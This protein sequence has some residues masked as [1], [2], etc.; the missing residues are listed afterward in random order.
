[1][2][3]YLHIAI[4][5][6]SV[7]LMAYAQSDVYYIPSKKV[8][9]VTVKNN[10]SNTQSTEYY[11]NDYPL[12]ESDV[13]SS[14]Y[15]QD[16]RDVDEYNRRGKGSPY[17]EEGSE[18]VD[19][20]NES[21]SDE[22]DNYN[23]SK[24]I[25]RFYSP[26]GVIVSSPFYW[27]VCYS[28]VWDAYYDG[29]AYLLPSYSFW[30]YAYDPWHYNRWWY[31]SCWDFTWGWYDPW[32][33]S[34]YWG[35]HRPLYWGWDRPCYGGWSHG[36]YHHH[37]NPGWNPG[38]RNLGGGRDFA[39]NSGYQMGR[40]SAGGR[41]MYGGTNNR[42][43]VRD[44]SAGIASR[45]SLSKSFRSGSF[46]NKTRNNSSRNVGDSY[47]NG[48]SRPMMGGGGF[49]RSNRGSVSNSSSSTRQYGNN[50]SSS[51]NNRSNRPTYKSESTTPNYRNNSSS[52]PSRSYG[53]SGSSQSGSRSG[54]F[55]SSSSRSGSVGG[56]GFSRSGGGGGFSR[57]GG[58]R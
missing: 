22:S 20:R 34:S 15:Y 47:R 41:V 23:Y 33:G 53:N 43:A 52:T 2:K 44:N 19:S 55:G 42:S 40:A 51:Y 11:N 4:L 5:F 18:Q 3:R 50:N 58:R 26:T 24:R 57:G 7:S 32:W 14:K 31:R 45:S 30:S 46:E 17:S 29:W 9:S 13:T 27:D 48:Y 21:S 56:G 54:G 1:M 25:I 49:S 36:G 8:K 38:H 37:F 12:A 6:C 16:N 35:W 28:D 10:N 39:N